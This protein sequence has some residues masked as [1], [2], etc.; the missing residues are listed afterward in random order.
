MRCTIHASSISGRVI[1]PPSESHA[2]RLLWGACLGAGGAIGNCPDSKE[3]RAV[4]DMGKQMGADI[5]FN[6]NEEIGQM[7]ADVFGPGEP[8]FGP[9]FRCPT[10]TSARLAVPLACVTGEATL[11]LPV[12]PDG[13]MRALDRAAARLGIRVSNIAQKTEVRG[14]ISAPELEIGDTGGA[15]WASGWAMAMPCARADL[16]L[17]LD[18]FVMERPALRLSLG[19]LEQ[20]GILWNLDEESGELT[21]APG[22]GY[23]ELYGDAEQD[24]RTGSYLLGALLLA[25]QGEVWLESSSK[26]A[27]RAFWKKLEIPGATNADGWEMGWDEEGIHARVDMARRLSLPASLDMRAYPSLLPLAMVLATQNEHPVSIEPLYP[28]YPG[29]LRRARSMANALNLVGGKVAMSEGSIRIEPSALIGGHVDCE[30]DDRVAMALALAGLVCPEPL[31]VENAQAV[32][33]SHP[34]FWADLK[35]LGAKIKT[36]F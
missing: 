8:R 12:L 25:G 2:V 35:S 31:I 19:V 16:I 24:W 1:P 11:A 7:T 20:F 5:G 13:P 15:F 21:I 23:P 18:D 17:S 10:L 22:Q 28:V 34:G 33:K 4:L 26:Q 36:D 9:D 29:F 14:E 3:V 27:E 6:P 30:R 32:S